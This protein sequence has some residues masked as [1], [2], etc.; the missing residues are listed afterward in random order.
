MYGCIYT[1]IYVSVCT[2]IYIYKPKKN[3]CNI[4][5]LVHLNKEKELKKYIFCYLIRKLY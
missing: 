4:Y 3:F 5:I 2:Y 1:Y